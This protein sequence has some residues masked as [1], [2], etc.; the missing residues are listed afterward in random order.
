MAVEQVVTEIVRLLDEMRELTLA[1]GVPVKYYEHF[2]V[3]D[4]QATYQELTK[5]LGFVEDVRYKEYFGVKEIW[6]LLDPH[7]WD[8]YKSLGFNNLREQVLLRERRKMLRDRWKTYYKE[9]HRGE[10]EPAE[11]ENDPRVVG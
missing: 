6:R 1:A 8:R 9:N 4:G 11:Q 2:T 5:L 3:F 7:V 10:E